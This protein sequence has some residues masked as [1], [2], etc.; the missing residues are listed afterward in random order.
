M[1]FAGRENSIMITREYYQDYSCDFDL[2]F[3]PFDTQVTH[4]YTVIKKGFLE[5]IFFSSDVQDGVQRA[6][7]DGQLREA[8][9]RWGWN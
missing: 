4:K 9:A 3:Y 8:G 7:Q 1:L 6:G 2:K 5:I